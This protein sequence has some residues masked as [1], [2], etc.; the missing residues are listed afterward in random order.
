MKK[1][2]ILLIGAMMTCA[3]CAQVVEQGEPAL[4]YYSPKTTIVLEFKYI[5]ETQEPGIYAAYAESMIG[6]TNAVK[7]NKTTYTLKNASIMT[8][9]NTDYSRPHK[10]AADEGYPMLLSISDK[11]LLKG[12]NLPLEETNSTYNNFDKKEEKPC[13]KK[14]L[15]AVPFPEEVLKAATPLAQANAA[16]KQIFHLRETRMYL[17]NG[18]VEH[19]PADGEAMRLVL[20]E[21]DKQEKALTELFLGKKSKHMD[22]K[23]VRLTPEM[24]AQ[25]NVKKDKSVYYF[26]EENGFTDAE[27]IDADS[28]C[29]S[30]LMHRTVLKE[31]EDTGKKGKKAAPQVSSITYNLPGDA[32]IKVE[33]KNKKLAERTLPI[34]QFGADVPLSKDLFTGKEL[35]V[36]IISEKTGNIKSIS[37]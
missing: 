7:E 14:A 4:V 18:E 13:A 15:K 3:V 9:T 17:L 29:V 5:V 1:I 12:Y 37:K 2:F 23:R 6:A 21:L 10:V 16:A 11:G 25:T 35:P 28:I 32:C 22:Y 34:A 19:A 26:S 30:M 24:P 8:A 31:P 27:N 36:I 33:Y 20:E